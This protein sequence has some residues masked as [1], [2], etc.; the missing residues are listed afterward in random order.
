[1][2]TVTT[3][4]VNGIRAREREVAALVE[5]EKPDV[6]CLQEVKAS[7]DQIPESLCELAGYQCY[8]HGQKGYSGVALHLR[9]STFPRG[10][11]SH[12]DFDHESRI[13]TAKVGAMTFASVYVPNG[14]K[15]FPA[16]VRFLDALGAWAGDAERAGQALV[17][18]GDLNV[19]REER[20]VHPR[21]RKP[22]QIG[23]TPNERSQLEHLIGRSLVDLSR[24]FFPDDDE[25]YTWWAPWR[26]NRQRNIGWRL[27]YVLAHTSLA[28]RAVSCT[29]LR[30]FGT[31]DHAPVTAVFDVTPPEASASGDPELTLPPAGPRQ[32]SLFT[33]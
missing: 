25:L 20:D 2:L 17:V 18:V 26:N 5:R 28:E 23:Q 9:R 12:P 21:L 6:L 31:S 22:A 15:D 16:K 13:V 19:A 7:R 3:W 11:Y 14:G 29:V 30:E 32:Q 24:K 33:R 1:M 8:W 4:N 27:D 10:A